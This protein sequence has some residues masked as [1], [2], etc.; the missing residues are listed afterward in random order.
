MTSFLFMFLVA[1]LIIVVGPILVI[2]PVEN[3][4]IV[5]P[6]KA[7]VLK[8]GKMAVTPFVFTRRGLVEILTFSFNVYTY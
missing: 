1:I 6:R 5:D 3:G 4:G 8:W 2:A 7:S